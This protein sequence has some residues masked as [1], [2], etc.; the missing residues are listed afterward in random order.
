VEQDYDTLMNELGRIQKKLDELKQDFQARERVKN[1]E[2]SFQQMITRL[3]NR[4][5]RT[6]D[7]PVAIK[8]AEVQYGGS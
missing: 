7:A 8:E 1:G 3:P 5:A 4:P 2:E 6:G